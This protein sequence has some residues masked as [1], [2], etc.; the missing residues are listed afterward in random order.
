MINYVMMI[1]TLKYK[2]SLTSV[3]QIIHF[4]VTPVFQYQ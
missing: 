3:M 2:E 1:N 4:I